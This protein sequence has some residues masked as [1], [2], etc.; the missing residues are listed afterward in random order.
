MTYDVFGGTLSLTQSLNHSTSINARVPQCYQ[1]FNKHQCQGATMLSIIQQ[2]SMPGC[3][4]AINHSSQSACQQRACRDTYVSQSDKYISSKAQRI[5][6]IKHRFRFCQYKLSIVDHL[7]SLS[8]V[9]IWKLLTQQHKQH[10]TTMCILQQNWATFTSCFS[11]IEC[12]YTDFNSSHKLRINI[13]I[14]HCES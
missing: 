11:H 14:V 6:T 5:G 3:H 7:L 1:S 2:A 12:F 8:T 4:N 13:L 9:F 10:V